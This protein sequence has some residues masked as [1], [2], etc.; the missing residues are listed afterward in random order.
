MSLID[1]SY[2]ASNSNDTRFVNE[3]S[4]IGYIASQTKFLKEVYSNRR[5]IFNIFKQNYIYQHKDTWLGVV[6]I[7]V[8]PCIPIFIY[9]ILQYMGI[10]ASS[11][12]GIPRSVYL[13]LGLILYY[14]FSETLNGF[15]SFLSANRT[16]LVGGGASKS[17]VIAATMLVPISNFL[18]RLI[19]FVTAVFVNGMQLQA[20]MLVVPVGCIFLLLFGASFGLV[21]SVFNLITRDIANLVSM[22]GFYLLF[23]SGVFGVIEP[24]NVF[25][26]ILGYS[27]IYMILDGVRQ[28]AFYGLSSSMTVILVGTLVPVFLFSLAITAFYR[29][30]HRINTF[31]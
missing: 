25:L 5:L 20:E 28:F 18:I 9:N 16:F 3:E 11:Y 2:I 8:N 10:F 22:I 14:T 17:A 23:A 13:T 27:P 19:L 12:G 6:W 21:L 29:V 1:S 24:T 7:F 26:R 15:T 4:P 31:L 30:E